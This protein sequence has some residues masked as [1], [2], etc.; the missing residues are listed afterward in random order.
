ML[1]SDGLTQEKIK[2]LVFKRILI[3]G[4]PTNYFI[5]PKIEAQ[6]MDAEKVQITP[7]Q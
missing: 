7:V 3:N 2:N 4:N 1:D 5:P 6:E